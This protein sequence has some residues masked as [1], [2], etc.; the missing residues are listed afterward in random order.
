MTG[1]ILHFTDLRALP[2]AQ[3]NDDT[4]CRTLSEK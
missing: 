4:M 1:S 3:R 2:P